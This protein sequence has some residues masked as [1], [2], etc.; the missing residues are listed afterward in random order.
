[1]I[2]CIGSGLHHIEVFI[3]IAME[4]GQV[5]LD[6]TR[7]LVLKLIQDIDFIFLET[8][9]SYLSLFSLFINVF[10]EIFSSHFPSENCLGP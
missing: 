9:L 10:S 4:L 5:S 3:C 6:A 7:G 2:R 1:M 8:G